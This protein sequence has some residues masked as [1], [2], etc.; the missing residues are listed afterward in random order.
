MK[1]SIDSLEIANYGVIHD[2]SCDHFSNINLIIGENGTGKSFFLKALYS[3]V[4]T[5]EETG[6]GDDNRPMSEV[7]AEKLRWTFQVDKIGDIVQRSSRELLSFHMEHSSGNLQ[8]GFSKSAGRKIMNVDSEGDRKQG[9]SVLIPAKEVLTL[10]KI[11]LQS[12]GIDQVFG[13]D[14]TYYDLAKALQIAPARGKNY[15]VFSEARSTVREMI[16]GKVD[17]D[18]VKEKWFY[19]DS[20]NQKFSIGATSEGVKKI[21]ILDRLLANGYLGPE[22]VIFF[23]EIESALHPDAI[24]SLLDVV[25]RIASEMGI[26]IFIASHSYYVIKKL[27]L[28]AARGPGVVTC[29]S[30]GSEGRPEICDL[31]DGLPDNSIIDTS[32]RLYEEEVEARL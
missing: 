30:L 13:F 18:E 11:I 14:D 1:W 2:F 6:R 24:C 27:A 15:H 17:Y 31:C 16:N 32:I 9:N 5:L 26:Q 20:A 10:Y 8:Y 28:I 21:A 3:A 23:D 29:I 7:L 22:S 4:R 12:R 19:K 25:D